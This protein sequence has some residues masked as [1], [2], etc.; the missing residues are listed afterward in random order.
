MPKLRE[1]GA[2]QAYHQRIGA[3]TPSSDAKLLRISALLRGALCA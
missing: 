1:I 2:A 3:E